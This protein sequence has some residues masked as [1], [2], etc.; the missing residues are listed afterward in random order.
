[1][2]KKMLLKIGICVVALAGIVAAFYMLYLS[3]TLK[4]DAEL[5]A[6]IEDHERELTDL[7]K[8]TTGIDDVNRKIK[9][10][11]DAI[12]FFESKL[13]QEKEVETVL[14]QVWKMA[15]ANSLQAKTI[16]TGM[17]ERTANYSQQPIEMNLAG[18]FNGFY[19]FLQ[20]LERMPRLTR[21]TDMQLTKVSGHDGEMQAKLNLSIFFEPAAKPNTGTSTVAGAM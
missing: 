21:I 2:A 11:E 19:L 5:T 6:R 17:T 14:A 12:H 8:S 18:D 3:P 16:K 15:E 13:P 9:E 1:M 4:H 20:Q 10:L 7:E